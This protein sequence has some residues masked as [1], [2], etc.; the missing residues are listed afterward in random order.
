MTEIN[1]NRLS[2]TLT[3]FNRLPITF[4]LF[5]FFSSAKYQLFELPSHPLTVRS[6]NLQ[7]IAKLSCYFSLY[8]ATVCVWLHSIGAAA[9]IKNHV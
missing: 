4:E 3:D 8:R 7:Q 5:D 6:I 2:P 9:T 1:F